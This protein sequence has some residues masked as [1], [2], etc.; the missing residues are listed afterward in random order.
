MPISKISPLMVQQTIN[1]YLDEFGDE[2]REA[3]ETAVRNVAKDVTK[4][5]K[6]AGAFGG[7][8]DY[9][10]AIKNEVTVKRLR[11]SAEIGAGKWGG[12]TH[13]LEFGHA[14]QNGGRTT[15]FNFVKPI[16][17]TVEQRFMK[18]MEALLK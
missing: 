13:L 11:V 7:T 4:D 16:N 9:R 10:K 18:E 5:L 8:G 15:A 3:A 6:K 14:K 12:L 2:A 1:Q 17:D